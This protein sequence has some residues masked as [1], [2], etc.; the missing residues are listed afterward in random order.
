MFP[1]YRYYCIKVIWLVAYGYRIGV[2]IILPVK[3]VRDVQAQLT[4]NS[5]CWAHFLK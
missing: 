1:H 5:S 3:K 4:D 2:D